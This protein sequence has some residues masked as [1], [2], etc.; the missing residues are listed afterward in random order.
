[1][2]QKPDFCL[3]T[4]VRIS[5]LEV[6]CNLSDYVVEVPWKRELDPIA[7]HRCDISS[8]SAD[9]PAARLGRLGL[10]L[11]NR[12]RVRRTSL[13]RWL[14]NSRRR[15]RGRLLRGLRLGKR[16]FLER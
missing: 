7:A 8:L 15:P 3:E 10:G 1:M 12:F 6:E 16:H 5:W 9:R 11:R 4:S 14:R 2:Y 13:C